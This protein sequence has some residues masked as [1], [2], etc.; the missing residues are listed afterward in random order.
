MLPNLLTVCVICLLFSLAI[1]I[2][3]P[4][5]LKWRG[6]E[7]WWHTMFGPALVF[8]SEDQDGTCV[9]LLNV[10]GTYQSVCYTDEDLLWIPVCEYHRSWAEAIDEHVQ[11]D[12]R[13]KRALVLGGGGYSF[14]K[15]LVS[16]RPDVSVEVVEIDP[17][18]TEIAREWF[19]LDTL[20][21]RFGE[22][23]ITIIEDDAWKVLQNTHD[24]FDII[25]NDVFS[26]NRPLGP[27]TTDQGARIIRDRLK[28]EGIYISNVRTPLEGKGAQVLKETQASFE[29]VFDHARVIYERPENPRTIGNN[30]LIAWRD[31]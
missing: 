13:P 29:Q 3:L 30:C 24:T 26:K 10:A 11:Q 18:I 9:R 17:Q 6:V 19:F 15:W 12:T 21:D 28:P 20:I 5:L 7:F 2:L 4:K 14:P 23:R 22:D 16:A 1:W 31:E 8:D 25:V 27:L